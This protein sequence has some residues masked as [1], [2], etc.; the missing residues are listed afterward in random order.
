VVEQ[1]SCGS[2]EGKGTGVPCLA[3]S[4]CLEYVCLDVQRSS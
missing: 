3:S 2:E 4:G 1:E